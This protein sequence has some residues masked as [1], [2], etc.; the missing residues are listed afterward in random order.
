MRIMVTGAS[1]GLGRA[2]IEGLGNPGDTLIGV[3][4]RVPVDLMARSQVSVDWI[5][6][7]LSVPR[8]G[9]G[10][11]A[12]GLK[13]SSLDVLI[14]NLGIWES[15][16]FEADYRF[17]EDDDE[18][19]QSMIAVNVTSA[20]LLVKHLLPALLRAEQPRIVL[21][22]STSG[23]PG[24]GRPEVAFNA[25]KYALSGIRDA[26]REGFRE[27]HLAVTCVHPGYLDTGGT[28]TSHQAHGGSGWL[29]PLHDVVTMVRALLELSADSFV[30]E[31]CIPAI[32]DERF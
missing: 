7:D 18:Q 27:Q 23:L 25:T 32:R 19:I 24:N 4:R 9:V 12:G 14:Y 1:S 5:P 30:R 31:I 22:G 8:V 13:D 15:R 29:I 26:L 11:V 17:Q 21:I 16:A 6:A 2:F 3:S 10:T 28:S 20:I